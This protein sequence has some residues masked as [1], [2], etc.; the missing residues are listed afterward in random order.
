[1]TRIRLG[2]PDLPPSEPDLPVPGDPLGRA[3]V[4][5]LRRGRGARTVVLTGH[6][7]TVRIDDYGE[8]AP[9]APACARSTPSSASSTPSS[10]PSSNC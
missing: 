5:A 7:D 1:M 9:L 10:S 3:A 8:L 6:F 2:R 4:V